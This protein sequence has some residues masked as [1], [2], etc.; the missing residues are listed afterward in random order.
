MGNLK[1]VSG[2][3]FPRPLLSLLSA[4]SLCPARAGHRMKTRGPLAP[5]RSHV[6]MRISDHYHISFK[7][8]PRPTGQTEAMKTLESRGT[9]ILPQRQQCRH[10][11]D[12]TTPPTIHVEERM[13]LF[14]PSRFIC[15][16]LLSVSS[17]DM[18]L[19]S[20]STSWISCSVFPASSR[21]PPL[22]SVQL[23]M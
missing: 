9:D 5:G 1:Y 21:L 12:K 17:Q 23:Q 13:K 7:G 4:L 10:A 15:F 22:L 3:T 11:N 2:L 20:C 6:Q 8:L 14:F 18:P 19:C 16:V